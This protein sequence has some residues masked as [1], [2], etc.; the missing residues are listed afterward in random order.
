MID[1]LV[2]FCLPKELQEWIAQ[3]RA[4]QPERAI[5]KQVPINEYNLQRVDELAKIIPIR[6]RYRGLWRND[7]GRR[8]SYVLKSNAV[9]LSVYPRQTV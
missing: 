6:R 3:Y 2:K 8:V 1:P 7:E 4:P 5:V 9:R